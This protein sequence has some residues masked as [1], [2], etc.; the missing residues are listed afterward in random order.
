MTPDHDPEDWL[1]VTLARS[2]DGFPNSPAPVNRIL[3]VARTRRKRRRAAAVVGAACVL[4]LGLTL[5]PRPQHRTDGPARPSFPAASPTTAT[6]MPGKISAD[7]GNGQVDGLRWSAVLEFYP[8][9]PEGYT[10]PAL[11]DAPAVPASSLLCR[12]MYIGGVRIDHQGGRWSDC[13]AVNGV[14]DAQGSGDMGL[15]GLQDKGTSGT[16][17]MV[18]S[19]AA[20]VAYGVLTFSD[21]SSVKAVTVGVPGSGYRAWAVPVADGRTI[22]AVDQYDAEDHRLTHDTYWH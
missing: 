6:A 9:L 10:P 17:L 13:Q 18:S 21:G 3:A 11:P 1:R 2:R 19:P 15:W 4:A 5:A 22:T 8:T 16:R 12:R 14:N 20:G 7:V